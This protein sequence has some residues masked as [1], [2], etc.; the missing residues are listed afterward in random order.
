MYNTLTIQLLMNHKSQ[1]LTTVHIAVL[2]VKNQ[3]RFQK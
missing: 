2:N 3:S 1:F